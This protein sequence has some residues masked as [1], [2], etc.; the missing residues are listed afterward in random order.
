MKPNVK[1]W[2]ALLIRCILYIL[3]LMSIA[4]SLLGAQTGSENYVNG[5][6]T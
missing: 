5:E 2:S 3:A 6:L 4:Q 1:Q